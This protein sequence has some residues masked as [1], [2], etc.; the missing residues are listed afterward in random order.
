MGYCDLKFSYKTYKTDN[1]ISEFLK[2]ICQNIRIIS[3]YEIHID[4]PIECLHFLQNKGQSPVSILILYRPFLSDI[5]L[6]TKLHSDHFTQYFKGTALGVD[7]LRM[8]HLQKFSEQSSSI[9]TEACIDEA[10]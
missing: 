10:K 4:H 7:I 1:K 3:R 6:Y 5:R 9:I 2:N 8:A